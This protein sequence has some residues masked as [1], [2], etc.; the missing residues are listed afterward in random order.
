M[1]VGATWLYAWGMHTHMCVQEHTP[2][3]KV[4]DNAT[5]LPLSLFI[6]IFFR[7]GPTL[8]PKVA[9]LAKLTSWQA[10]V[11]HLFPPYG[12]GVTGPQCHV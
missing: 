7:S 12:A 6:I 4:E 11:V 8:N 5:W 3:L 1:C 10:P 2:L 9:S